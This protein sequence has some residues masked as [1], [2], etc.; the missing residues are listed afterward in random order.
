MGAIMP[1]IRNTTDTEFPLPD[2]TCT[3][4]LGKAFCS[5]VCAANAKTAAQEVVAFPSNSEQLRSVSIVIPTG[6]QPEVAAL[7]LR[8]C[9][10]GENRIIADTH[11]ATGPSSLQSINSSSARMVIPDPSAG[12]TTY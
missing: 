2:T 6:I 1:H 10:S 7:R 4:A 5:K 8:P 3:V 9:L 12:A 11:E